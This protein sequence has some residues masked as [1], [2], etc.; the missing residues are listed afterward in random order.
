MKYLYMSLAF[1]KINLPYILAFHNFPPPEYIVGI[2]GHP[3]LII[4]LPGIHA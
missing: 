3:V 1:L 2:F 4:T